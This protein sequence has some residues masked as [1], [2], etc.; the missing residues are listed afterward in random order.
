MKTNKK[1]ILRK[2]LRDDYMDDLTKDRK[3]DKRAPSPRTNQPMKRQ[4]SDY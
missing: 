1:P 3:H 4:F 2:L